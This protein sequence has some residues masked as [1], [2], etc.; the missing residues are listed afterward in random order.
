MILGEMYAFQLE[1]REMFKTA[2]F[3]SKLLVSWEVWTE[4]YQRRPVKCAHLKQTERPLLGL[5]I[6]RDRNTDCILFQLVQKDV[7]A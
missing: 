7:G 4:G 2:D 5:I 6:F 1:M 3:H